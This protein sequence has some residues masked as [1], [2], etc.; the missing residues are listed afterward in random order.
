MTRASLPW[1]FS[2]RKGD[3]VP[4]KTDGPCLC[5]AEEETP[6][7]RRERKAGGRRWV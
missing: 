1:L 7:P 3:G 4:W 5:P 6:R 2:K